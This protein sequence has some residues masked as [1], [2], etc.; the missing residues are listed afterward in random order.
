MG[1]HPVGQPGRWEAIAK[2]FK[3]KRTV[4]SVIMKAKEM[5]VKKATDQDSFDKF[6]KDKG[7]IGKIFS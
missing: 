3:G 4:E 2:G 6:L 7:Y 1:K 5:G